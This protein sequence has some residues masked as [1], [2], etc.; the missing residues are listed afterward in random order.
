MEPDWMWMLPLEKGYE[1]PL[2]V[3]MKPPGES[4]LNIADPL[5]AFVKPAPTDAATMKSGAFQVL[6]DNF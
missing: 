6:K 2:R 3:V 4:W 5:A 1:S